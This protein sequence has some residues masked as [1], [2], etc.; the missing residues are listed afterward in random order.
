MRI[1]SLLLALTAVARSADP[2]VPH[3]HSGAFKQYQHAKPSKYGLS[4]GRVPKSERMKK[5]VVII[6]TLPERRGLQR[7]MMVQDVA[8]PPDVV[9]QLLL[10]F[11]KYP[12]F[13]HGLQHCKPY[14]RR[15]T[16]TGGRRE[17][18]AYTIKAFGF[19]VSY[20]LDHVYE[21][22]KQSMTWTLDYTKRSDL[23]DSVGY[24]YVEETPLGSRVYY[25]QDTLLPPWIPGPIRKAFA[26]VA[27]K[28]ATGKLEPSCLK[29]YAARERKGPLGGLKLPGPLGRRLPAA[30]AAA[31]D[32]PPAPR[33][34]LLTPRRGAVVGAVVGYGLGRVCG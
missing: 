27:M 1:T 10:D 21:P 26:S 5:P 19:S 4:A 31:S 12:N 20:Y 6:K 22:L 23:F 9:W 14:G 2:S 25:S 29:L 16:L 24:W 28:S 8:V 7:S 33:G 13:I 30:P 11:P 3:I 17:C 32:E 18:A 34:A 15:R